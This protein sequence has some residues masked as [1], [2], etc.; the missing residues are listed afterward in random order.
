MDMEQNAGHTNR[1]AKKKRM[2]TIYAFLD[3]G[4]YRY[5]ISNYY[6]GQAAV[7]DLQAIPELVLSYEILCANELFTSFSGNI[8]LEVLQLDVTRTTINILLTISLTINLKA[9]WTRPWSP[10][11][12]A[13]EDQIANCQW[14]TI[15]AQFANKLRT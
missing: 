2:D 13:H 5:I 10:T 6:F 8:N 12:V 3:L 1:Q 7:W 14:K 9:T 15:L 11:G 4:R